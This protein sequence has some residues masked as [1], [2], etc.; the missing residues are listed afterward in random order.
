MEKE[1]Y[2]YTLIY[3]DEF[4]FG[5]ERKEE[6]LSY[7]DSQKEMNDSNSKCKDD[8]MFFTNLLSNVGL[9]GCNSE[10]FEKK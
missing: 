7:I 6:G 10:S 9:M 5:I 1:G 3:N 8:F 4:D 2:S